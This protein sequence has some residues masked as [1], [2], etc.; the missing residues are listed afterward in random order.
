VSFVIAL[1]TLQLKAIQF[2]RLEE[3]TAHR[4]AFQLSAKTDSI[5]ETI[6]V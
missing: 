2:A 6:A 4:L 5:L 1:L 3:H